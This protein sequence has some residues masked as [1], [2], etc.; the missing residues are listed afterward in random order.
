MVEMA[1]G[2]KDAFRFETFFLDESC[3]LFD[4][5]FRSASGVCY[6]AFSILVP[7][8]ITIRLERIEGKMFYMY[9]EKIY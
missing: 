9:H 2:Q 4:F 7:E 8:D 1:V 5:C 6:C 3:Q